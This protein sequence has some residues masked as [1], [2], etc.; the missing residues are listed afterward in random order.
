MNAFM[1]IFNSS[2]ATFS[3]L[4]TTVFSIQEQITKTTPSLI[5]VATYSDYGFLCLTADDCIQSLQRVI[6]ALNPV[7]SEA[8]SRRALN[9]IGLNR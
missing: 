1:L 5:G 4:I 9:N 2:L 6:E 7:H 8:G 3:W